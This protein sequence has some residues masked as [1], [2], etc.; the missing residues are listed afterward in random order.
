VSAEYEQEYGGNNGRGGRQ[1]GVNLTLVAVGLAMLVLGSRFFVQGAS[2]LARLLG[3]SDL[4]IGL[5]I[6]ALGTSLP[7]VAASVM[8]ALKGERDI[9]VGNVVGSNI[10]NLLSVLALTALLSPNGVPVSASAL[11]LDLPFMVAVAFACLPIFL[12]R[13]LIDRWEGALFLGYYI[14]YTLYLFLDGSGYPAAQQYRTFMLVFVAPLTAVTL[15]VSVWREW[16][17]RQQPEL[18]AR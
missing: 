15:L 4:V 1:I 13:N 16:R 12:T 18:A 14:A 6:V 8:A 2:D 11:N 17:R 9:A 5:T 3:L 10:F 7:E